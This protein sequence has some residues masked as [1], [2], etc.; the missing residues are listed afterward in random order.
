[1]AYRGA[2]GDLRTAALR[3]L[4]ASEPGLQDAARRLR[5]EQDGANEEVDR[6][7]RELAAAERGVERARGGGW[8]AWF[9]RSRNA[10][11]GVAR[12]LRDAL[13]DATAR[14]DELVAQEGTVR[15]QLDAIAAAR[16]ELA[17]REAIAGA[18]LRAAD[19]P[20]GADF[21][22]VDAAIAREVVRLTSVDDALLAVESADHAMAAV[23][24]FAAEIADASTADRAALRRRAR[25]TVGYART[26]L[27]ELAEQLDQLAASEPALVGRL[28]RGEV[29]RYAA[30]A[31]PDATA[32][33]LFAGA[34]LVG[35]A[36]QSML[37]ELAIERDRIRV[38]QA[39]LEGRQRDAA[40]R[41]LGGE[42]L[43]DVA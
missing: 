14:L 28:P 19:T 6:F 15:A 18:A 32:A 33:P 22:A 10:V 8:R 25:E 16:A 17:A 7:G 23:A 20:E 35:R 43:S 5:F 41:Y 30:A 24:H 9:G 3:A 39:E 34:W 37:T 40:A 12:A 38:R 42:P 21:R 27:R 1:M 11:E 2:M 31:T 36:L 13:E 4:V 29:D 26:R